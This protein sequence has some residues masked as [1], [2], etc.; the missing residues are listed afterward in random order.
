M[1]WRGEAA[2]SWMRRLADVGCGDGEMDKTS[3]GGDRDN[4]TQLI[5]RVRSRGRLDNFA[6]RVQLILVPCSE[7]VFTIRA[8]VP[9]L[10]PSLFS[11]GVI[12][13]PD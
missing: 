8:I 4:Y 2:S 11:P 13:I 7:V 6:V 5:D 12:P 10:Q 1:R 3:G 9:Q